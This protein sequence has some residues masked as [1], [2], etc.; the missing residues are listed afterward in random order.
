MLLNHRIYWYIILKYINKKKYDINS[1]IYKRLAIFHFG[2]MRKQ[3]PSY[4]TVHM[5]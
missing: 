5:I 1:E 4:H 2:M 3:K